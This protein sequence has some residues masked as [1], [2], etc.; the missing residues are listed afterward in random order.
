MI[1]IVDDEEN[2]RAMLK[3][4]LERLGYTVLTAE[5]GSSAVKIYREKRDDIDLV[6]LDMVMPGMNGK[7]TFLELKRINP[8]VRVLLSSGYAPNGKAA[9][10][11]EEG[12]KAFIQKPFKLDE[13]ARVIDN[14]LH[15]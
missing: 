11:L 14:I 7:E 3:R 5:D 8:D 10:I 1:L 2:V 4:V 15:T 13:L 12:A 9:G 6:F